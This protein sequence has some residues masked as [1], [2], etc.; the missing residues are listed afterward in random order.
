M[1]TQQSESQ[2]LYNYTMLTDTDICKINYFSMEPLV[3]T[4]MYAVLLF[5]TSKIVLESTCLH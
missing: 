2:R 3:T 1:V 5:E 4:S